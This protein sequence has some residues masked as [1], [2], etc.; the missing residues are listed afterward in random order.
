MFQKMYDR[1][2][3]YTNTSKV[4][5]SLVSVIVAVYRM[6][7][8]SYKI[9][10]SCNFCRSGASGG[11]SGGIPPAFRNFDWNFLPFWRKWLAI[12]SSF[13]PFWRKWTRIFSNSE[14]FLY[15][16]PLTKIPPCFELFA[17]PRNFCFF[18]EFQKILFVL[19]KDH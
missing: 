8:T 14:R 9:K 10:I 16:L 11:G 15:F 19:L 6:I 3:V 5:F 13:L 4:K 2:F 17:P 1:N 18:I 12:S 7:C